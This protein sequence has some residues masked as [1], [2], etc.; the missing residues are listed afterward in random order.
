MPTSYF[1]HSSFVSRHQ[2]ARCCGSAP[3]RG[4]RADAVGRPEV[5]QEPPRA[6]VHAASLAGVE[7]AVLA[8][9]P[10]V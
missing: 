6:R 5:H 9:E 3:K 4:R 1:T 8:A 7:A 10:G 2:P